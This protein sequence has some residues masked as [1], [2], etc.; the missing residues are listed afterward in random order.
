MRVIELIPFSPHTRGCSAH[1]Q[2]YHSPYVV[3]PAYAGMFRRLHGVAGKRWRFP[4]IRGDVP[5]G[6]QEKREERK[7][8][9]HTRGC[10]WRPTLTLRPPRVFPAYAGMF[11]CAQP[12]F[13]VSDGF[14]R[15]RGDVPTCRQGYSPG[16]RFSPHTRGCSVP[17]VCLIRRHH[18]FPAYAGMFRAVSAPSS[19]LTGF[20]RIRGDV[21]TATQTC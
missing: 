4:R 8:S 2:V 5:R 1:H 15:I 19:A 18:V 11:R 16:R 7:F 10:S 17:R 6:K 20:P 21:P 14:P 12:Y 3:F 13:K 9:P